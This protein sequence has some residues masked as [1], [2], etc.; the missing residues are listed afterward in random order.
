MKNTYPRYD[1]ETPKRVKTIINEFAESVLRPKE[2]YDPKTN[3]LTAARNYSH[4][5]ENLTVV[6]EQDLKNPHVKFFVERNPGWMKVRK[7]LMTLY[8][9]FVLKLFGTLYQLQ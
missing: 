3:I 7:I 5:K 4:L 6:T 8:Q 1:R 9:L 2:T